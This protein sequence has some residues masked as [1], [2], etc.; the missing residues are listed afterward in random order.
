LS[1]SAARQSAVDRLERICK[2]SCRHASLV[3]PK[4]VA[5]CYLAVGIAVGAQPTSTRE[6]ITKLV[7]QVQRADYEGDR[8]ALK[9][10]Y[11]DL[12]E[13]V[14]DKELGAKVQ[15]WR[16][17]A[18]WRRAL[19]GFNDSVDR[20]ELEQDLKPAVSEFEMALIRN[21]AFVD[22]RVGAGSCLLSLVFIHQKDAVRVSELLAKAVPLLKEAGAAEPENPRYLW[23]RGASRWSWPPG[24]GAQAAAI[25]I[26][27]KGLKSA[28]ERKNAASDP[29]TPS[30]GEPE[31]LMNLAWSNLNRSTPDLAA[32][33]QYA[34]S[35][36]GL[37]PYWHYVKDILISQIAAARAKQNK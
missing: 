13:F 17:F 2:L 27:E 4:L 8:A 7:I 16:G 31:L 3:L 30:W 1:N 10:R 6:R 28:R 19:N 21:P 26:Y 12:E 24:D 9:R 34:R 20:S 15:Y 23:V 36:L 29:L 25:A 32:A 22:A 14:N 5:V 35:A 11:Q 33:E 18:F 37:V